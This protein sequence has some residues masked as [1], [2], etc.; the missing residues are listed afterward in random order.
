MISIIIPVYNVEL[1]VETCIRSCET[2]D[3]PRSD[4]EII[5]IND[6]STDN[7]LKV[8]NRIAEEFSNIR[9][10][11]QTNAGLSAARNK[12]MREARGDYYMFVDSDDWI[13]ENCLGRLVEK[14]SGERPD[15]L[16]ICAANAVN[17]EYLRRQSYIDDTP[18]PGR[19]LLVRGVSPC[20]PFSIWSS[21]FFKKNNLSFYEGIFHE[22]SELTP[23]AYYFAEKVSFSNEIIYYVRQNPNSITRSTNPQKSFDLVNVV[24]THLADFATLVDI[25]YQY[26]FHNM[27]SMY[28]NNA[29]FNIVHTNKENQ[30][31]LNRTIYRNRRIFGNLKRSTFVKYR[32]EYILFKLFPWHTVQMYKL[33]KVTF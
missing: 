7:S 30:Q 17:G 18:I 5:V 29:L 33:L 25:R 6:G 4:Y 24:C 1:F 11:S 21:S 19:D 23:R 15:A 14:L 16:A 20:A 12:G 22:D 10:F 13:A 8:I 3:I 28:L 27:V 32:L 2:Q 26:I 9:V 31:M